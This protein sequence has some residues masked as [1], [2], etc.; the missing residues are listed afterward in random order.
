MTSPRNFSVTHKKRAPGQTH[1][2]VCKKK[3]NMYQKY[4]TCSIC[5]NDMTKY[6]E[7]VDKQIIE[8]ALR[9]DKDNNDRIVRVRKRREDKK[10]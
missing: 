10:K 6:W 7:E 2:V 3:L 4:S 1:C 5:R 8:E 9:Q